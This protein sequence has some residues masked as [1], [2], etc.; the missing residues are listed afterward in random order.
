MGTNVKTALLKETD[1]YK[2]AVKIAGEKAVEVYKASLKDTP[3]PEP[4]PEPE[5]ITVELDIPKP[6]KETD[7]EAKIITEKVEI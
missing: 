5:F 3:K 2:S 7:N 1:W 4:K 6:T